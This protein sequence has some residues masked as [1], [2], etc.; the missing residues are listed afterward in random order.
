[1]EVGWHCAVR[2]GPSGIVESSINDPDLRVVKRVRGNAKAFAGKPL[3]IGVA[4]GIWRWQ[5]G[6]PV[7]HASRLGYELS[8]PLA[9]WNGMAYLADLED[10]V[11]VTDRVDVYVG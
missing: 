5:S 4:T 9:R 1:M 2:R 8:L 3:E 7:C 11:D 10:P 6:L